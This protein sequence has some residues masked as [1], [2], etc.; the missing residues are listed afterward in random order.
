M[1]FDEERRKIDEAERARQQLIEDDDRMHD[2][3]DD[4]Y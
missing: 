3:Y 2:D 1:D 4:D